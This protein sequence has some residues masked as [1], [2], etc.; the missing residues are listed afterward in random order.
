MA[1]SVARWIPRLIGWESRISQSEID[2][3][4]LYHVVHYFELC[5]GR[6]VK[7]PKPPKASLNQQ[8]IRIKACV[9]KQ[10]CSYSS[11]RLC[12]GLSPMYGGIL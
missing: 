8:G 9:T 4:R 6:N 7:V 10:V 12:I 3:W 11:M 5:E 2:L 1:A